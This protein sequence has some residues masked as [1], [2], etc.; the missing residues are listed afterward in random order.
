MSNVITPEFKIKQLLEELE[1]RKEQFQLR[2][3]EY[4]IEIEKNNAKI[5]EIINTMNF[6]QQPEK[7]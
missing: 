7:E 4:E 2:V 3:E 5:S 6:L 1:S